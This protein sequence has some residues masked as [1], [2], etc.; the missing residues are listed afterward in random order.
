MQDDLFLLQFSK[1]YFLKKRDNILRDLKQ[2]F[3][4]ASADSKQKRHSYSQEQVNRL[5]QT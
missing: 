1:I 3:L 2:R 5:A 4:T